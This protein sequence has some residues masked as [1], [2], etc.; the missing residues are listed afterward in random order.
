MFPEHIPFARINGW[1]YDA[2]RPG[3][4]SLISAQDV[5]DLDACWMQRKNWIVA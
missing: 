5:V 3:E 4:S 1:I 2:C